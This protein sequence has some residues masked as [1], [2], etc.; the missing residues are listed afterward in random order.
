MTK[1]YNAAAKFP[2]SLG[3]IFRTFEGGK[4]VEEEKVVWIDEK[5]RDKDGRF[6]FQVSVR[7]A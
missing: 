5:A 2:V 6:K 1:T 3:D 4:L 7:F